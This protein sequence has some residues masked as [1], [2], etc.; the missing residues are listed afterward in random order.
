MSQKLQH[1]DFSVG[2]KLPRNQIVSKYILIILTHFV[3]S[4]FVSETEIVAV[5]I[6]TLILLA[7]RMTSHE[8]LHIY[9]P[10]VP[11]GSDLMPCICDECPNFP[12]VYE[13]W[14]P[15]MTSG[16]EGVTPTAEERDELLTTLRPMT[17][18]FTCMAEA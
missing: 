3:K 9:R 17:S 10:G 15:L 16:S 4:G 7:P 12:K 6:L 18:V 2:F 5:K 8:S 1:T 13:G 11:E 14:T